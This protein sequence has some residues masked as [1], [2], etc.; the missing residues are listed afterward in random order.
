LKE[1]SFSFI[2]DTLFKF[3]KIDHNRGFI[4][5]LKKGALMYY[6]GF[7]KMEDDNIPALNKNPSELTMGTYELKSF[8][9]VLKLNKIFSGKIPDEDGHLI[10]SYMGGYKPVNSLIIPFK[11]YNKPI[12]VLYCDGEPEKLAST[13]IDQIKILSNTASL[14]MQITILNEKV[15]KRI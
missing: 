13:N 5:V 1:Q 6:K 11:I 7:T 4:G 3:L 10:Q 15:S 8:D 2:V 9:E 12:A 14:A